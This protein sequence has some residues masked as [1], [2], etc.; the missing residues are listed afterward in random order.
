MKKSLMGVFLVL[1]LNANWAHAWDYGWRGEGWRGEGIGVLPAIIGGA[2]V[3]YA[4]AQPR[5]VYVQ[6]APPVVVA[7]PPVVGVLPPRPIFRKV[8]VYNAQCNCN[9]LVRRQVGWR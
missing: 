7:A 9:V 5:P 8:L 4:I 6:P 2:A 3:G 1:C